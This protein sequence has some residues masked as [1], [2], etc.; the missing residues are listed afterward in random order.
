[1]CLWGRIKLPLDGSNVLWAG[2]LPGRADSFPEPFFPLPSEGDTNWGFSTCH[3]AHHQELLSIY[4]A[5]GR[6][7]INLGNV[8]NFEPVPFIREL[9]SS[10]NTAPSSLNYQSHCQLVV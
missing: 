7:R 10:Q 2:S 4:S 8:N 9:E 1:M 3:K 6:S 5:T